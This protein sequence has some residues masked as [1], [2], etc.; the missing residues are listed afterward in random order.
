MAIILPV[1]LVSGGCAEIVTDIFS[2]SSN[3]KDEYIFKMAEKGD[4]NAQV[5]VGLIYERG[6]GV[7]SNAKIAM[8]W[9]H[10]AVEQ[11][12]PLGAFHIGSLYERGMGVEQDFQYAAKYYSI[13]ASG[14]I[15]SGFSALA[16][17]YERGLGVKKNFKKASQLYLLAN[18]V[19]IKDSELNGFLNKPYSLNS[20]YYQ[21]FSP[22]RIDL[23]NKSSEV[24][25]AETLTTPAIEI[26]LDAIKEVG[27]Q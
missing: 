15:K 5:S 6:L 8:N 18:E 10:A 17:L 20:R 16:Y 2:S 26:N 11:G 14:G 9:Y 4:S 13:A 23:G 12:N 25:R 22:P 27:S 1:I 19:D 7:R 24:Q 21:L 3:H